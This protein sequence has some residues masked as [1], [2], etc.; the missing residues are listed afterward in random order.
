MR[1]ADYII[2]FLEDLGVKAIF[3]VP[4]GGAMHL[5]DALAKSAKIKYVACHH[6]QA[7][8]IAAEAYARTTGSLGV[9]MVTTGPGATN[10]ITA[11]AGAWIESIPLLI[12]SGQVKRAD[13]KPRRTVRQ[14][15]P[16]EVDIISIVSSITKFATTVKLPNDI[17]GILE[18]ALYQLFSMR[19]GPA[20]IDVPLDIQS[21]EVEVDKLWQTNKC[22]HFKYEPHFIEKVTKVIDKLR[23]ACR[24]LIM[25]GH[26]VRL[27]GA[28]KKFIELYERLGVPIVTTWN[29]LDLI[30]YHHSLNLGH[31]GSVSLRSANFAIQ[32]CDVLLMVGTRLDNIVTAYNPSNFGRN[33]YRIMV[34]IDIYELDKLTMDLAIHADAAEFVQEMLNQ[35][36]VNMCVSGVWLR[37]CRDLKIKYVPKLQESF[38][39]EEKITHVHAV[40]ALSDALPENALIVTG[41][42]GLAIEMFYTHFQ[43]KPGQRI[44]LNTGL[45]AMGYGLPSIVGAHFGNVHNKPMVAIESDGSF[46][47]NVQELATIRMLQIPVVIFI[48]NNNGYASI[49]NTQ[50][51]YFDGRYIATGPEAGLGFPDICELAEAHRI[52]AIEIYDVHGLKDSIAY[53]LKAK[54][55]FICNIHLPEIEALWPKCSAIVQ[56]DGTMVSMP[57]EDMSPLLSLEELKAAML[58]P[59]DPISERMRNV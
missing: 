58:V 11:V 14:K 31:P 25:V 47:M 3:L 59:L 53:A 46:M 23:T 24:P 12:I 15:G 55:P 20:W 39:R 42:S 40:K 28:G 7:A 13:I 41:S 21:A 29:A 5:N 2:Q 52:P 49:R 33:A 50:K 4:G 34:D 9:A 51:N 57:L 44:F 26:G 43:N 1:V 54:G 6:E 27:A 36:T 45:G 19:K 32:N 35:V 17:R 37:Y 18:C 10:A 56:S 30:P 16:Q 8:A 38:S 22:D 48:L